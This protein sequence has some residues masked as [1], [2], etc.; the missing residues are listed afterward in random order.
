[1][2]VRLTYGALKTFECDV[3]PRRMIAAH[4]A[5]E[6]V[7]D[8]SRAVREAIER[9]LEFPPLVQAVVPGDKVVVALERHTPQAAALVSEVWN[10]LEPRDIEPADLTI[11]QP[12]GL[13]GIPLVDPR[14]ALP[15]S[16]R[17]AVHWDVHDPTDE[18]QQAYLAT[19]ANGERI[20]LAR[21]LVEA[22]VSLSVGALAFDPLIGY[23]GTSSVFYPGLSSVSAI[24]KAHGLGHSELGP[25]DDRPLRQ[26]MDEV[27]WL[28]GSMFS[29]QV[30]PAAGTSVS[31]VIAGASDSVLRHGR[32][33]LGKQWRLDVPERAEVVVIAVDADAAGHGWS[34]IGAAL[35][36]AQ[37]LVV[38]GGR[39]V[40]LSDV[41]AELGPGLEL[42]RESASPRNA[43]Q[44]LRKLA[45]PDLISATQLV[46]TADWA[47]IYFLSGTDSGI[48]DELFMTALEN[49]REAQ[50][51][52]R[53][54]ET[55][56]VIAGAQHAYGSVAAAP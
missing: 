27:G 11:L 47:R 56:I 52:L 48:V 32:D 39:I 3:D 29:I 9:P 51:L 21:A 6:P 38:K 26:L 23:R 25:D 14:T 20:Y 17:Q 34:Q 16:V 36:V 24:S 22:D 33:L 54:E 53:G 35:A 55:C 8:V 43:V 4:A 30:V 28:L 41:S 5:P 46:M 2:T 40:V 18:K 49:E 44:P 45:P 10:A 37:N 42:V 31:A 50:R 15:D 12:A 1:M 13:D 7:A 19:T